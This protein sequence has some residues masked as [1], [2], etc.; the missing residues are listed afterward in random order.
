MFPELKETTTRRKKQLHE[1]RCQTLSPNKIFLYS[2][3][4]F[5][6]ESLHIEDEIRGIPW[7]DWERVQQR[8]EGNTELKSGD[9]DVDVRI[10]IQISSHSPRLKSIGIKPGS[11][12][13]ILIPKRV[14]SPPPVSAWRIVLAVVEYFNADPVTSVR[15]RLKV[16]CRVI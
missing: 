6:A 4:D 7:G 16:T 5:L 10:D 15:S 2:L 8:C 14:P 9:S 11:G 13:W 1:K 3:N 12:I